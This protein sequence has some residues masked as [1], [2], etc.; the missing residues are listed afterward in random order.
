M[1]ITAA[2]E[3]FWVNQ[4]MI[5]RE[6][7]QYIESR[8]ERFVRHTILSTSSMEYLTAPQSGCLLVSCFDSLRREKTYYSLQ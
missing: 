7:R 3:L 8:V 5:H 6:K 4:M 1:G 2:Q